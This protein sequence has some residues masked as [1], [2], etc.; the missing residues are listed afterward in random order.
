MGVDR[1]ITS[2]RENNFA[3]KCSCSLSRS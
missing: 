3:G 1:Q 2:T